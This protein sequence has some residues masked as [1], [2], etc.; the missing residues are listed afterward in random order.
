M[1][2]FLKSSIIV[3]SA[4]FFIKIILN[5][6]E[7][8]S[9]KKFIVN[10]CSSSKVIKLVSKYINKKP[11]F[12]YSLSH[13]FIMWFFKKIDVLADFIHKIFAL[14][15]NKSAA[16]K[17]LDEIKNA[18]KNEKISLISVFIF[19]CFFGLVSGWIMLGA[20]SYVKMI[21]AVILYVL[22]VL[23]YGMSKNVNIIETSLLYKVFCYLKD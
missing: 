13:R 11:V 10:V 15:I 2:Y 4:L 14:M 12:M 22:A 3:K 8:S 18:N 21:I 5:C 7:N 23:F 20:F 6:Y 17:Q 16:K 1:P 9:L 19:A